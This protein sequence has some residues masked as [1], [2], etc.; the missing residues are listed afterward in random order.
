M[1]KAF[2]LTIDPNG[3]ARLAFDYPGEKV[4]KISLEVLEELDAVL[5]GIKDNQQIKAL[6]I[7]SAKEKI[8]IAGADLKSFERLFKNFDLAEGM[9]KK[10]HSVYNKLEELP[11]P[12]IAVIDGVCLGGGLELALAC[13]YRVVGDSSKTTLGLPETNLGIFPGWGGTQRLPRLVGLMEGLKMVLTG[14]PV[15]AKKAFKI[16]LADA[17]FPSEFMKEK[18]DAFVE[19]ILTSK[20]KEKVLERR[21]SR[22]LM[23]LLFERNPIGRAFVFWQSRRSVLQK[24]KGQYPSPL[25]ALDLIQNTYTMPLKKG[26][27]KEVEAFVKSMS[28]AFQCAPN[29]IYIFFNSE[30]MKK[31]PGMIGGQ[32]TGKEVKSVGVLGAGVMG[33]GI[34]W[35]M[36]YR[37]LPVRMKDVNWKAVGSGF[38]SAWDTYKV[39]IKKRKLK[40]AQANRKFHLISGTIDYT[41]FDKLDFV[42]EAAV[43]NLELKHKILKELEA[44]VRPDAIIATNTSSLTIDELAPALKH[45]E[46]LVGMHFFNPPARMPLVEIVSGE[47]TSPEAVQTVFELCQRLKKTPVVV[48]DCSGFL[49]NRVFAH[50][51]VE[52]MRMLEEGVPQER[53]DKLFLKF[54]LPMAPFVLADEIGNDVNLKAMKSFE[55]AYGIRMEVPKLLEKLNEKQL[56]GRKVGKGFYIYDKKSKK[57]NPEITSFLPH[58]NGMNISDT[59]AIDRV[60]L[61]MINEAAR[62]LQENVIH[63]PGYLDM[64]L[65][66]GVGFPPFRGGLL[67]YADSIGIEKL[68]DKYGHLVSTYGERFVPC[69]KL[70]EMQA[71]RRGFF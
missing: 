10:G 67:R 58:Q 45:P 61:A 4:N 1:G 51:F 11:F 42:I 17:I 62:C 25:A 54:G 41:G 27:K 38:K 12:S 5:E 52:I 48:G 65:V 3:I 53:L 30:Q 18:T 69:E 23:S 2:H 40:P 24:T 9:I 68:M 34:A 20:G 55:S 33:S 14:R 60:M 28:G 44:N 31:D 64:A 57:I 39:L 6:V 49:V 32:A 59:D 71:S 46:R 22:G 47:K 70:K 29:L 50:G 26:L 63:N 37:D 21:K 56:Y 16:H 66:F 8:F 15:D 35:L 43:E 13:T 19:E 7:T 36:S